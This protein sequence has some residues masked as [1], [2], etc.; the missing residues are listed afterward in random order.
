VIGVEAKGEVGTGLAAADP[1]F[2]DVVGKAVAAVGTVVAAA[3]A[4]AAGD[5]CRIEI[6][7]GVVPRAAAIEFAEGGVAP[8]IVLAE[9]GGVVAAANDCG[10]D[11]DEGSAGAADRATSDAFSGDV[12]CFHQ[13]QRGPDWQPTSWL[14]TSAKIA[15]TTNPARFVREL[16]SW[17]PSRMANFSMGESSWRRC[18]LR[19]ETLQKRIEKSVVFKSSA[20]LVGPV[21]RF[22]P[23]RPLLAPQHQST[24]R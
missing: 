10:T 11:C 7:V 5:V 19:N 9:D 4:I 3:P 23:P 14:P 6:E 18:R 2:D 1:P 22:G 13:A 24:Q 16:I 8:T 15:T 20:K 12:L 21:H 17:L